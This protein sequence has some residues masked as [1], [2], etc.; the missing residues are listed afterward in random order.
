MQYEVGG[1]TSMTPRKP[2][3]SA[4]GPLEAY[5]QRFDDLFAQLAQ[6]R[7]FREYLQGLLLPRERNKTLTALVGTEPVAGAQAAAVQRLQHFVSESTWEASAVNQRR[8]EML[9][10]DPLTTTH[11]GGVLI[12]DD[13]GD[14]KSGRQ[15]AHVG[16]QYLGSVGKIDNGIVVVSTLWADEA[17]YYPLH[18]EPYTPARRLPKGKTDPAFRTKPRIALQ[19]IEAA[20]DAGVLFRAI[21]ADS[22]YGENPTFA[23]ALL[24][25]GLPYVV[26]VKPSEG[27]WAPADAVHTPQEAA[28]ELPWHGPQEPGP[29][30]PVVRHFRD[31]HTETWWAAELVYGPYGPERAVRRIVATPDP[32]RLPAGST[33]YLETNLPA[34]RSKQAKKSPL[35]AAAVAEVVQLYGLR[36]WVE[37][38]YKQLKGELG[39][40]DAVVRADVALRR[41]WL[42]IFCAF[43]FCWLHWQHEASTETWPA[44]QGTQETQG[45]GKKAAPPLGF[46][47][48][49]LA[50]GPWLA[51]SLGG[52]APL[53]GRLETGVTAT[54][55]AG[56]LSLGDGGKS[57]KLVPHPELT[58]YR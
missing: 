15:T 10:A 23:E 3:P 44:P 25:E 11:A 5:A 12:I 47:A 6:R 56:A 30:N 9:Q 58:N 4:P 17:R 32:R 35:E 46:M 57:L 24:V 18:A 28:E 31:G 41:H 39:W 34:P 29:W 48:R 14:R 19:L 49:R 54:R 45:G 7:S 16:R 38:G 55:S 22:G 13:T 50:A 33:W 51:D 26:S 37:Q 43:T 20:L 36:G 42:L 2:C 52:A 8:L 27:I 1:G 21:V 40:A 53:V